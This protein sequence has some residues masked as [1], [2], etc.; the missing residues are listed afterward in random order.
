MIQDQ[1]AWQNTVFMIY[2]TVCTRMIHD[3]TGNS[4]T[5]SQNNF[6]ALQRILSKCLVGQSTQ[7]VLFL[8][9]SY[10]IRY[11]KQVVISFVI[12]PLSYTSAALNI[13]LAFSMA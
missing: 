8:I 12:P 3:L 10:F 11:L 6:S 2:V 9:L 1:A 5:G 4:S 13:I 7:P